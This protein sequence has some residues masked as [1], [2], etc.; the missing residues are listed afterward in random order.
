MYQKKTEEDIRCPLE[1]GLGVFGGKW[2]SR[3]LCVLDGKGTLRYSEIRGEIV[4][5]TDTALAAALKALIAEGM[6][7]RVSYDEVPPRVEYSLTDKGSS[8]IPILQSICRWA[9]MYH[10]GGNDRSLKMCQK[11]DFSGH[12]AE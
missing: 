3:V 6:V 10:K 8:A 12:P 4:D 5:I 9:G 7:K 1:Y 11:C 2:N